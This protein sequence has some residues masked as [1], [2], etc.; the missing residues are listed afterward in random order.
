MAPSSAKKSIIL[1]TTILLTSSTIN[2]TWSTSNQVPGCSVHCTPGPSERCIKYTEF[3]AGKLAYTSRW[4]RSWWMVIMK[5]L[6]LYE[7]NDNI[8]LLILSFLMNSMT[9]SMSKYNS[10][11]RIIFLT[12]VLIEAAATE[13]TKRRHSAWN[14]IQIHLNRYFLATFWAMGIFH[15]NDE[16]HHYGC[17]Y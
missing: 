17:H 12:L 4:M 7:D 13:A 16:Y 3:S 10:I 14:Q 11:V 2:S 6:F 1:I 9:P 5:K 8:L 15:M